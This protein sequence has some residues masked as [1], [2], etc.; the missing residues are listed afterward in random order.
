MSELIRLVGVT[1]SYPTVDAPPV[2]VLHGVNLRIAAGEFVAIMG[3]SGSGKSTLM[4]ILGC[5][6]SPSSGDYFLE[7]RNIADLDGDQLAAVRLRFLGFVFQSFNLLPRIDVLDNVALPL[8][9]AGVARRERHRR[10]E[11]LLERV[12][13]VGYGKRRPNQ[14]SGGQQQRVAIA[15]ALVLNPALILADEPTGALDSHT[16]SDIMDLFCELNDQGITLI[17]VTHDPRVASRAHR[18][19]EFLDGQV[20]GDSATSGECQQVETP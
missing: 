2:P 5:L 8:L 15:R 9:Y 3:A 1:K 14:L 18:L 4:N 16:G 6:D 17:T 10:A 20:V 7:D 12:G 19:V 13:L 11:Q